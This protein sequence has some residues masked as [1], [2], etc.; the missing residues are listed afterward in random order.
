MVTGTNGKTTTTHMIARALG[1]DAVCN[2]TGANMHSGVVTALADSRSVSAA[3]EI[4]EL[5]FPA[6]AAHVRPRVAVLLNATRDQLD[7]SHEVARVAEGWARALRDLDAIVV[8]NAADPHVV[9]ATPADRAIWC[10]PGTR[11]RDDARTCPRCGLLIDWTGE[12]WSCDCGFAMP[13]PDFRLD[14][15]DLIDPQGVRHDLDLRLPGQANRGNALMAVAAA[16]CAGID[17]DTALIRIAKMSEAA[18]RFGSYDVGG[19]PTRLILAKNPAGMTA[20]L[21]IVADS[22]LVIGINARGVDGRDTSWLYDVDFESLA[23]RTIGVT[24]ERRDDLALRLHLAGALPLVDV[25]PHA[26]AGRMPHGDLCLVGNYS[27]FV[28]W[29]KGT[30]WPP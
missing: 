20:A 13:D 18:G 17:V 30:P 11:W 27:N 15:S 8:A 28:A 10:D 25:D 14:G 16:A 29:R 9:A 5:H 22:P 2:F 1:D 6:L 24:G 12:S 26:L 4:D 23:G 19:R 3:L 7:R 21:D